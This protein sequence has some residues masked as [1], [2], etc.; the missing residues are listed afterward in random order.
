MLFNGSEMR[1]YSYDIQSRMSIILA[2]KPLDI[3]GID[4]YHPTQDELTVLKFRW[5]AM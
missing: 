2:A 4:I 1:V 3:A 5:L